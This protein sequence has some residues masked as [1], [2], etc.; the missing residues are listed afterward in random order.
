MLGRD[1]VAACVEVVFAGAGE[2]DFGV[3]GGD[4]A[5]GGSGQD[6]GREAGRT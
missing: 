2:A 5:V 4:D 1:A 3:D 6:G